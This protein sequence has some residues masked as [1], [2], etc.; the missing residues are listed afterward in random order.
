[1]MNLRDFAPDV[2]VDPAQY[3]VGLSAKVT[4]VTITCGRLYFACRVSI[5]VESDSREVTGIP[6]RSLK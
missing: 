6:E 3:I 4:D 1:M 2:R 5:A